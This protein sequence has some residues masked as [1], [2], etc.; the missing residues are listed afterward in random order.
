MA[1]ILKNLSPAVAQMSPN[2]YKTAIE[3]GMS[4]VDAKLVDQQARS[5]KLAQQLL[6]KSK[7]KARKEFL[8]LDPIVKNNIYAL[9]SDEEIFQP[10]KTLPQKILNVATFPIRTTFKTLA[11]P[12]VEGFKAIEKYSKGLNTAY[13]AGRQ[14]QQGVDFSKALLNDSYNGYNSWKWDEVT[15]YEEKYGK[16]LITLARGTAEKRS[17][18]KSI[19]L[20]GKYDDQIAQAI[21]YAGDNPDKFAILV[22]ELSQD[23]QVSP[24]RDLTPQVSQIMQIQDNSI[25]YKMWKFIGVD[26]KTE[27][28]ARQFKQMA[29]G[30]LDGV[31][32]LVIDPLT[33]TGVGTAAKA[34]VKGVGNYPI[35]FGEAYKRFGGFQTKGQKLAA[36]YQ[37]VAERGGV[38]EGM[39]WAFKEPSIKKLWDDQLGPRIKAY[40]EAEGPYAKGQVLE[41][42]KFDFPEW[43]NTDTV[44]T[45]AR[46]KTFDAESARKF[47][48]Y[49]DDTNMMLNGTVDGLSFQRNAIPFARRTRLL[50][51]AVHKTAYSIF[52]PTAVGKTG[53]LLA[54]AEKDSLSLIETLS[55]VADE[56]NILVN[57]R[58]VDEL[59]L[60]K[61]VAKARQI[62]F[63]MGVAAK[64]SPGMIIWGEDSARTADAI[65][66]TAA[67]VLPNDLANAITIW[68][69]T[70]PEN[71]QLTVVRNMQYAFMKRLGIADEDAFG[72]LASTYND[73]SGLHAAPNTPWPEEWADLLHPAIYETQNNIPYLVNRG[74]VHA[75]QLKKGIAPLPYDE[76]YR[77]SA[78]EKVRNIGK[79][80]PDNKVTYPFRAASELFGG[81][82]RSTAATRYSNWWSAGTLAPRL[83]IRT[84]VD[85]GLMYGLVNEAESVFA[86]GAS[87][88]ESDMAALTAITGSRSG[89]GP[90]KGGFF[91]LAKKL[92][93]TRANGRPLDP[94]DSIPA[95]EREEIKLRIKQGLEQKLD[96][97]VPMSEISNL[98]IREALISVA[99]DIYPSVLGTESWTNLKK[100]MRHQPNFGGAVINSM[101]AKS[102]LGGKVTPDF[103][104]STFGLDSFS[105]FLKEHGAEV[106]KK[107]TPRE[108]QK[109]SEMETGVS[110][111]RLFNIRFGFNEYKITEGRYF[112]PVS[113]FFRHNA[114]R[115]KNDVE[116]A[117]KEVL[118]L[119][120]VYYDKSLGA[121]TSSNEKI[122]DLAL[123]PFSQVIGLRQKGYTDPEIAKMLVDDM[124]ADMRY[125]FHGSAT[126]NSYNKKLYDLIAAREKEVI[127]VEDKLG[128]GYSNTWSKA[129]AS[130]SWDEYNNATIGFRPITDYINSDIIINNKSIDLDGLKEV[131][132]FGEM[133]DKFPNAIMEL[134]D[135]QVTGFFRLPALKVAINKAF[136]QLK[137]YEQ[138]LI[139][140]HKNAMLESD[141]FMKPELAQERAKLLAEKQ[142]SEIAVQ[143]ASN[144]VLEYVDNPNIRSSFAISIRHLGRF[145]RATED[146]QRR[147][148]RMYTKQ[149]LR[150]LYR[151]RLLHMGLESAGSVYTDEKGD[152]YIIF[153]TDVIINN[154]INPVLAKLTGNENL[155]MP[156]ATQMALKWRLV[157]P[158]FAPDAGAPAF[159]GPQ[160]AMAILTAKAFLRELPLVP[161]R[162]KL[163]P[164]TNWAA[165]KLDMFAMGH[166]GKNTD[167]GEALKI[168]MPMFVSGLWGASVDQESS[169]VKTS[170]VLQAMAYHQAFGYTLPENAT[171]QEKKDYLRALRVSSN[172]IIIG[173]FI[174][175]NLNPAYP[176]LKD[177]AG[178]PDFIK[179][180]GISSFKS[181]F[182][183]IYDGILRNAGPDVTDPFGLALATFVGKNPKKL[184]YIVPRNTKAMQVF[185]NKTDNLKNW[186][187]KNRDF[188]DTYKEIGYMFAPKVGEYNPDIYTFMEA[189]ELVNEIGLLDY[190]EKIQ[191]QADKEEYFAYVKQEKEDL[192]KVAD[193]STRKAIAAQYQRNRQLLMYSNPSLEEAINNP[194]NRGTLKKQLN[195]LADAVNAPKSPIAK[196]TRA[197][198]QL[199]I[200]KVR[201]FI[202]FNENPY[203]KNA[204]DFQDKKA[205]SKE[206]LGQLLFDLSRSNLEI[207]EANRLIFT[208]ILNSY[209]RNVV[210]A[211][212][213]R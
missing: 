156:T 38:E 147:M 30:P 86:L 126:V 9:F 146:F 168:A 35:S 145:V 212:P 205:A 41:S 116:M 57:T 103:F 21:Q 4:E 81:V 33:Y 164:Y 17:L 117:Q 173:Q 109:L 129:V 131:Q 178:L 48:T 134:M 27:K 163:S 32:Q 42:M 60:E 93:I 140:R 44:I 197:S 136:R 180:T 80:I 172:N 175:G 149:P 181:S 104:E 55:K 40:D 203:A 49:V 152:D 66:S 94:R 91:W 128:R 39:A 142:T 201:G 159:A 19:D 85:E 185:I 54:K 160:A 121:Y 64:R 47:F 62:L 189:E 144:A 82:T 74:V 165:D 209:A 174:L 186:V 198:M 88:F 101:S 98:E 108:V 69:T 120:E 141:P 115:T 125:V 127:K 79:N 87:K 199:I 28:G 29:S 73:T 112:S 77:L 52:N 118:G 195:V 196:D 114:L 213:E 169:R 133:M 97:D 124:L 37:F 65:R 188:V 135:H 70:Q 11:S 84:N 184:A 210:S 105:L 59:E 7:E 6:T 137:P 177:T 148:F 170:T 16:A 207:R 100:V 53:D 157:N 14:K 25:G 143:Q 13:T 138:M 206:E 122:T 211:S 89:V 102:I 187:Q 76:L 96:I 56:D 111:W 166:I 63:K 3:I 24:G 123:R 183:D 26:L 1:E 139:T 190:L 158:S 161:F 45:L 200:Q 153:P 162:D 23:A 72:I 155:K 5:W 78:R 130:L 22:D 204:Y 31:Y 67:A 176:T 99:E 119:M 15:K 92:G 34:A 132:T 110:M 208:P 61:D 202:D 95:A 150:A 83:G 75:G 193:Y 191:T 2:L 90:V 51:S 58:I 151:M 8:S 154:A 171:T 18:G 194:D 71:V 68:L 10:E 167:L 36:K 12:L 179:Q 107:W 46:N 113:A 43:Y 50:T 20:Y 192:S 106:G 182:W